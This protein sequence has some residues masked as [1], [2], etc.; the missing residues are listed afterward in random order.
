[1]KIKED[2]S[3]LSMI[4]STSF[5]SSKKEKIKFNWFSYELSMAVF[6]QIKK[7]SGNLLRSDQIGDKDLALF[8]I[9]FSKNMQNIILQKLAGKIDTVYISPEM[10]ESYFPDISDKLGNKMLDAILKAWDEQLSFCE[11]CPTRCISEKEVY[12]TMF[13]EESVY[14]CK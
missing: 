5:Y 6:D 2:T 1:M 3:G 13:D 8:S 7:S 9:Y 4:K 14:G 10:I 12:C 11:T